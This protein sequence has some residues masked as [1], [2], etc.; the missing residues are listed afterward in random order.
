MLVLLRVYAP[1]NFDVLVEGSD[2][3]TESVHVAVARAV[4]A[5]LDIVICGTSGGWDT[6][7]APNDDGSLGVDAELTC[8][9]IIRAGR[10]TRAFGFLV[11]LRSG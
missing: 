4:L 11:E 6:S 8:C 10:A 9:E 5:N 3:V 2:D 7:G 1:P